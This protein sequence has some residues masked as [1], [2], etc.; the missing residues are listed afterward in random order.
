MDVD[1]DGGNGEYVVDGSEGTLREGGCSILLVTCRSR[2][3]SSCVEWC[4]DV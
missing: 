2:R 4:M 3:G 1:V